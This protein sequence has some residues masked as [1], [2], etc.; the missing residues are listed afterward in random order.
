[1]NNTEKLIL[2]EDTN[3]VRWAQEFITTMEGLGLQ[4]PDEGLTLSWFAGAI[5]TGR[6]AGH[7]SF[8]NVINEV[9]RE[10]QHQDAKWGGP[11]HDDQH[12]IM[13]FKSYMYARLNPTEDNAQQR[14]WF[15]ELAALAIA[16]VESMDRKEI[17]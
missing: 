16:A 15:I 1:M 3:G 9:H 11:E 12:S 13:D 4:A 14:R 10:R 2:A 17:K 7:R 6:T 5:E 8:G